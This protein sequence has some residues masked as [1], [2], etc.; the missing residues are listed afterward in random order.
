M[1]SLPNKTPAPLAE[2][3][4]SSSSILRPADH[5]LLQLFPAH[6]NE[7]SALDLL[8]KMLCIHPHKRITVEKALAHPFLDSLH[9]AEDEPLHDKLFTFEFE[10]D[11][12][13]REKIQQLIWNEIKDYHTLPEYYPGKPSARPPVV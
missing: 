1:T 7:A 11:V 8:T 2:V 4:R 10:H 5:P 12:L 6:K 3:R 13:T 9:N